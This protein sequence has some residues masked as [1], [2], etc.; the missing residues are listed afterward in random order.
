MAILGARA[1][2]AENRAKSAGNTLCINEHFGEAL[3]GK[4]A[5]A[6]EIEL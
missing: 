2:L 3:S 1:N 5:D 4:F 6:A